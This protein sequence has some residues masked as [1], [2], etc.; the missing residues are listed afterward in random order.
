MK[1]QNPKAE[2]VPGEAKPAP[3]PHFDTM[4]V[5][6]TLVKAGFDQNHAGAIVGAVRDA[7]RELA[8]KA[9]LDQAISGLK[10]EIQE[11]RGDMENM[12]LELRREIEKSRGDMKDEFAHLYRHFWVGTITAITAMAGIF[13]T[14]VVFAGGK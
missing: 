1:Q 6:D 11:V 4:N 8:T 5:M 2:H 14:I 13:S 9:D 3:T 10:A 7:Q 12:K